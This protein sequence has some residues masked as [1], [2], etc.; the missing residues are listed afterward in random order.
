MDIMLPSVITRQEVRARVK[1]RLSQTFRVALVGMLRADDHYVSD[2][3]SSD[4]RDDAVCRPQRVFIAISCGTENDGARGKS[5]S[6]NIKDNVT[7]VTR[8]LVVQ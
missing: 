4:K 5:S 3:Q 8:L 6:S 1:R 7:I 2:M